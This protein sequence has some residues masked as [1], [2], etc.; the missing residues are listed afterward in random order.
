[1]LQELARHFAAHESFAFETT[2]A[3]R[4]YLRHIRAWEAAGYRVK[5]IF[6]QLDTPEAAIARVAQRVRQGGHHVPEIAIRRRLPPA[7]NTSNACTRR[8][9]TPGRCMTTRALSPCCSTGARSLEPAT[10]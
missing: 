10:H 7:W 2:L 6:L 3:G 8:W 4:G 9:S 1:M 5:L